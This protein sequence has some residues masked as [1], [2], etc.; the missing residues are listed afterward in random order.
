[1]S[2]CI[3]GENINLAVLPI[4]YGDKQ[5]Y[6]KRQN[7]IIIDNVLIKQQEKEKFITE[8]V[9][10][11]FEKVYNYQFSK[12]VDKGNLKYSFEFWQENLNKVLIHPSHIYFM[13]SN[14]LKNIQ[15]RKFFVAKLL[16]I[17]DERIEEL[18]NEL[19]IEKFLKKDLQLFAQELKIGK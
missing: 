9:F 19:E 17:Q 7:L 6:F 15:F 2:E 1:M 16:K 11:P 3:V 4:S 14:T 5:V 10:L 13:V 8:D 18:N 12:F